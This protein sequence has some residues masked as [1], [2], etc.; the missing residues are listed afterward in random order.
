MWRC[1]GRNFPLV[2]V[3]LK[4]GSWKTKKHWPEEKFG[5]CWSVICC[6]HVPVLMPIQRTGGEII[7][8]NIKWSL[9][10][11]L[12]SKPFTIIYLFF[13]SFITVLIVV[14]LDLFW[15]CW[16]FVSCS[17]CFDNNTVKLRVL[18]VSAASPFISW[19]LIAEVIL[20]SELTCCR[21]NFV[22][23]TRELTA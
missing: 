15:V 10:L 8:S 3:H 13:C 7:F 19:K 1:L 11:G 12:F 5:D 2:L 20:I 17:C 9:Y 14:Y 23:K 6:R 22:S 21:N 4:T 16:M 18:Y